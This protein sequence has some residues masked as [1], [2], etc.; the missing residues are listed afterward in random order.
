MTGFELRIFGVGSNSSTNCAKQSLANVSS[1]K[2]TKSEINFTIFKSFK[3]N[4][5]TSCNQ[6]TVWLSWKS[7]RFWILKSVVRIQS[8][9]TFV[10]NVYWQ[11]YWKDKK[12]KRPEMCH[13]LKNI[14]NRSDLRWS[15]SVWRVSRWPTRL[16]NGCITSSV[17]NAATSSTPG[18]SMQ[19]STYLPMEIWKHI[20]SPVNLGRSFLVYTY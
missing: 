8:L 14:I 15:S 19:T 6:S 20:L 1:P 7:G 10:F 3:W 18:T 11:L 2:S 12:K 4:S 13:F 17:R 5:L 9:T 16:G